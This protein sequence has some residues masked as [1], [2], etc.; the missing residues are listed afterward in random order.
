[1]II[2]SLSLSLTSP[3]LRYVCSFSF[4]STTTPPSISPA[5]LSAGPSVS[6]SVLQ[7]ASPVPYDFLTI[8][9]LH[10]D[11]KPNLP[12]LA[13][14]LGGSEC[15]EQ[16]AQQLEECLKWKNIFAFSRLQSPVDVYHRTVTLPHTGCENTQEYYK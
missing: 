6:L 3:L 5:S 15:L 9:G 7:G 13:A 4:S 14:S 1:M 11:V 12:A 10:G 8:K 2:I 16:R